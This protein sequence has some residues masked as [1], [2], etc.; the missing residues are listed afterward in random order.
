M[1]I[2]AVNTGSSSLK[3]TIARDDGA[4]ERCSVDDWDGVTT[5]AVDEIVDACPEPLEA[6]GHRVVHGGERYVEPVL[7]DRDVVQALRDL[8]PL[9]PLHQPR[10]LAAID[11]LTARFPA[12]PAVACFDTAFHATLPPA[13]RTYAVPEAWR[14]RW[15]IRRFG[16]HGL[17][18][19]A[20]VPR[21]AAALDGDPPRRVVSCHLGAGASLCAI[22]D[23]RSVDTTMGFTPLEGIVMAKR[24]GSVD[25]GLVL[26]LLDGRLSRDEVTDGLEQHGGLAALAGTNDLREVLAA[27]AAGDERASLAFDVYVHALVRGIGSMAAAAGGVDALVFTAGVGENAAEVRAAAVGALGWLG[28]VL[29]PAVNEDPPPGICRISPPG[30]TASTWIVPA[31]EDVEIVRATRALAARAG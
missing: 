12:L 7:L 27:R 26:W 23:G 30:A 14:A 13:A 19:G 22:V 15:P 25:P 21:L 17:S 18:H 29:D 28:L 11:A 24:S 3:L 31:E 8:T 4:L 1:A 20:V 10:A 6:I 16:F 5:D 9:A 2:L